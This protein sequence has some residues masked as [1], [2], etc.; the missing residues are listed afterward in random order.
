MQLPREICTLVSDEVLT[1]FYSVG[2]RGGGLCLELV[3]KRF[4]LVVCLELTTVRG[5]LVRIF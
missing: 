5:L 2:K 3:Q 1:E 4:S